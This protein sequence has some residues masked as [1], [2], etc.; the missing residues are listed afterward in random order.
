MILNL[1]TVEL[2]ERKKATVRRSIFCC[3]RVCVYFFLHLFF[4]LI[5]TCFPSRYIVW[6][7]LLFW[8]HTSFTYFIYIIFLMIRA[9]VWFCRHHL[10]TW[11]YALSSPI[12][13]L[14]RFRFLS[15][16]QGLFD[17]FSTL[18]STKMWPPRTTWSHFTQTI[19]HGIVRFFASFPLV[20]FIFFFRLLLTFNE[21]TK[22]FRKFGYGDSQWFF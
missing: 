3:V 17:R 4:H 16:E 12:I 11:L 13:A 22:D 2:N 21:I 8:S 7:M 15:A 18:S 1:L 6:I 19:H 9:A 14:L 10:C 5:K 20:K